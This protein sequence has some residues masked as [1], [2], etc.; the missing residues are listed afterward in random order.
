MESSYSQMCLVNVCYCL[1]KAKWLLYILLR[2]R[3]N[4]LAADELKEGGKER[5]KLLET[6]EGDERER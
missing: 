3:L 6:E 1:R 2:S 4:V 5:K